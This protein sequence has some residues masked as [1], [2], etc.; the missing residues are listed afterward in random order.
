MVTHVQYPKYLGSRGRGIK[1]WR[2]VWYMQTTDP[3]QNINNKR[4]KRHI[5]GSDRRKLDI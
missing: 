2:P 4:E 1:C 5:I 3:N